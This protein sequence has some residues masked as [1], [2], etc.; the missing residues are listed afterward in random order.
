VAVSGAGHTLTFCASRWRRVQAI[1]GSSTWPGSP[2]RLCCPAPWPGISL[3]SGRRGL[4]GGRTGSPIS[5]EGS[6]LVNTTSGPLTGK[7]K[8]STPSEPALVDCLARSPWPDRT[9]TAALRLPSRCPVLALPCGHQARRRMNNT[10]RGKYRAQTR[11]RA[12]QEEFDGHQAPLLAVVQS[13]RETHKKPAPLALKE[14]RR[15]E[16]QR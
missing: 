16:R 14:V 15:L 5:I 13:N 11:P 3:R 7:A 4:R 8:P 9:P 12:W 10:E 6:L 1:S 2:T